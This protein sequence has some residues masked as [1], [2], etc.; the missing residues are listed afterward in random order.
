MRSFIKIA[1][2]A[3]A[4]LLGFSGATYGQQ[5]NITF[6]GTASLGAAAINV[7]APGTQIT[8]TTLA[9]DVLIGFEVPLSPN[10]VALGIDG[11]WYDL[12]EADYSGTTLEINGFTVGGRLT[13]PL[14]GNDNTRLITRVGTYF[15]DG[16]IGGPTPASGDGT[17]VYFAGGVDFKLVPNV[18]FGI[19]LEYIDFG[20]ID[21]LTPSASIG[22]YF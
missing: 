13:V 6:F 21:T 19:E 4:V 1:L 12:G 7:D 8:D 17:D 18:R 16:D 11:G 9:Y 5:A 2:A 20:G 22:V 3:S 14:F 15:W 10:G